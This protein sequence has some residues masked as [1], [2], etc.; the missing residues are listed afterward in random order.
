M[1]SSGSISNVFIEPEVKIL[2]FQKEVKAFWLLLCHAA[3]WQFV[4]TCTCLC[5]GKNMSRYF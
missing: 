4:E 2:T 5:E 1:L 3:L